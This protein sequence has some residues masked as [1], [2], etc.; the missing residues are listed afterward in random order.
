MTVP[1][2]MARRGGRLTA[3]ALLST[4]ALLAAGAAAVDVALR[5]GLR[6]PGAALAFGL[7]VAFGE[8]IRIALPRGRETAPLA[9]T[10]ALAYALCFDL[11]GHKTQYGPAEVVAVVA[12]GTVCGVSV[13]SYVGRQPRPG[14]IARRILVTAY[15]ALVFRGWLMHGPAAG[16]LNRHNPPALGLTLAAVVLVAILLDHFLAALL[17]QLEPGRVTG[18]TF[19]H[20]AWDPPARAGHSAAPPLRRLLACFRA[21]CTATFRVCPTVLLFAVSVALSARSLGVWVLPIAAAPILVVQRSLRRYAEVSATYQ[22]TIRALSRVTELADYTEPGHARRVCHLSLAIGRDL[23]LPESDLLDLEYAALLHDIGQLSLT[24]PIPGGATVLIAPDRAESVASLGAAVVRQTGVL[25]QVAEI[26]EHQFQPFLAERADEP[27]A[28]AGAI[29]RAANAY[30]DLVGGALDPDR[31]LAAL[32]RI[33][34][35]TAAEYDPRVV[36]SLTR[37]VE[38][39]EPYPG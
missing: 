36:D 25:D 8:A 34:L 17:T 11:A 3:P 14:Y 37:I 21:D 29:I 24:D 15:A 39:V 9:Q 20:R 28:L 35:G 38:A 26:L 7:T 23:A 2:A 33:R 1:G 22:Q 31:R 30:D 13:Q 4:L 5:H 10:A 27:V 19:V 6:E 18:L 16:L 32:Q 12:L